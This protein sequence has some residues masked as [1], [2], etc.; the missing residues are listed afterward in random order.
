[1]ECARALLLQVWSSH[2]QHHQHHHP[3][4]AIY[5][6]RVLDPSSDLLN[7]NLIFKKIDPILMAKAI[8]KRRPKF[9][10][11]FG[12]KWGLITAILELKLA[13]S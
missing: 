5:K 11:L 9:C 8:S 3:L 6:C 4:G 1:M 13:T 10:F 12:P 7:W 2:Q